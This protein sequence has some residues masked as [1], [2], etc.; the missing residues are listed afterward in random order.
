MVRCMALP[1]GTSEAIVT[2]GTNGRAAVPTY[3]ADTSKSKHAVCVRPPVE[4]GCWCSFDR[5]ITRRSR[6]CCCHC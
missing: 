4:R 6:T 3:P 5:F 1:P 2:Y